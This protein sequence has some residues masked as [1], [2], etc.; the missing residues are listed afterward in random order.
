M[1]IKVNIPVLL[2]H[3]TGGISEVEV[4]GS[5]AG[6]VLHNVVKRFPRLGDILFPHAGQLDEFTYI[7]LNGRILI[8]QD[9]PLTKKVRDG[10][11]LAIIIP[12]A[13]G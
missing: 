6:E 13:G 9:N 2:G 4:P 12:L 1:S 8:Y 3:L 11:E 10:D 5:T 7:A